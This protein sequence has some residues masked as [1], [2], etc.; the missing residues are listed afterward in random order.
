[1]SDILLD[2][3][4]LQRVLPA[5]WHAVGWHRASGL[6]LIL[7]G[8][9]VVLSLL[10]RLALLCKTGP[11]VEPGAGP[12]GA[13]IS[14]TSRFLGYDLFNLEAG[15]ERAFI[16]TYQDLGFWAMA[17]WSSSIPA[18]VPGCWC[19]TRPMALLK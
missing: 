12:S 11:A 2:D 9:F 1:M 6:G 17:S 19:P 8:V 4:P 15:R 3:L 18:A 5:R 16:G 10:T 13:D 14:Y 7:G